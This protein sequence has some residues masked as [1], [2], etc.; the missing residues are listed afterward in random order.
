[1]ATISEL[2][3][4]ELDVNI[5]MQTVLKDMEDLRIQVS[6]IHDQADKEDQFDVVAHMEDDVT[7]YNK[8]IWVIQ[9]MLK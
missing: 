2:E 7:N 5:V 6:S 4:E 3:S 9:S 1:M 8:T